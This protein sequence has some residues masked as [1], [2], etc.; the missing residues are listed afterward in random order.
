MDLFGASESIFAVALQPVTEL[1]PLVARERIIFFLTSCTMTVKECT[2]TVPVFF[3]LNST[4]HSFLALQTSTLTYLRL[5][6][7][8]MS[9]VGVDVGVGV[10]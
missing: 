2:A 1:N 8:L 4:R 6:R 9:N 7:T 5:K 3:I 10:I